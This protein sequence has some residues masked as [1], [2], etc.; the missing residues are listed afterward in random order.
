M[1]CAAEDDSDGLG[2]PGG[3]GAFFVGFDGKSLAFGRDDG[4]ALWNGGLVDDLHCQRVGLIEF[5]ACKF[6]FRGIDADEGVAGCFLKVIYISEGVHLL[7]RV[8]A[9]LFS[10]LR[11]ME[12]GRKVLLSSLPRLSSCSAMLL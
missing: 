11:M 8:V 3:D 1:V 6:D 10:F 2:H 9:S 12:L 7:L 4:D 5:I